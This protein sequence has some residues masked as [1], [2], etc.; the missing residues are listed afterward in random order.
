MTSKRYTPPV[1]ERTWDQRLSDALDRAELRLDKDGDCWLWPGGTARGYGVISVRRG[2][3][4]STGSRTIYV[5]RA[6]YERYVG[7]I[8]EGLQ[9]DHLCLVKRCANPVHLEVVTSRENS[10]RWG[11]TITECPQGH[12]YD[13]T[14]TYSTDN[15]KRSWRNCR[16]CGRERAKV[17]KAK[18]RAK[19]HDLKP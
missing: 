3:G 6:M 4:A 13:E 8:P 17:Y 15:G 5:H 9:L 1:D 10:Q 18:A 7:P 12:L 16:A 2:G 11:M 19:C 14:N